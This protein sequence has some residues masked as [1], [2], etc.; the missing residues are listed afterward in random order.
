MATVGTFDGVHRGHRLVIEALR[1]EA[2]SRDFTPLLLTFTS[3]PLTTIAPERAPATIMPTATKLR[4]LHDTGINVEAI[5][6]D[7]ELRRMTARQW[8]AHLRDTYGVS[9]LLLGHDN[10]FGSDGR[11]LTHADYRRLAAEVGMDIIDAPVQPGISSSAIRK[12]I[13]RGDMK[14]AAEMLGH[15]FTM[16]GCVE[17]GR[18]LGRQLGF[19]TANLRTAEGTILPAPGVYAAIAADADTE[20]HTAVLNIGSRPTVDTDGRIVPEAH[21]CDINADLYGRHLTLL[22]VERIRDERKFESLEKL[23]EAIAA[24]VQMARAITAPLMHDMKKS[25]LN[26]AFFLSDAE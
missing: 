21:I 13:A 22:I 18:Q 11:S 14:A 26:G 2:Q 1:H 23:Q 6:F 16:E 12:A 19:P 25:D 17:H 15:P 24:D 5:D 7:P 20:P 9:A 8:L 10:T 3:H 4:L